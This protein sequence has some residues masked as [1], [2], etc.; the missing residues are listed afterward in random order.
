MVH[1]PSQGQQGFAQQSV[2]SGQG[3]PQLAGNLGEGKT[4]EAM[5]FQCLRLLS[6][7]AC[8]ASDK[9]SSVM[10]CWQISAGSLAVVGNS[11]SGGDAA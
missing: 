1:H 3:N 4:A 2:G 10:L 6:G 7:S 5:Q 8:K 11:Q 9:R